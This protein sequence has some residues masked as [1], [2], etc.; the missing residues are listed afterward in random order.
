MADE[1]LTGAKPLTCRALETTASLSA[2]VG[3]VSSFDRF[4]PLSRDGPHYGA[5]GCVLIA[6]K[7]ATNMGPNSGKRTFAIA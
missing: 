2:T 3:Y 1:R 7:A 5:I 6:A 4:G